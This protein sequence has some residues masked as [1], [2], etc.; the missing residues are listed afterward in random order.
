M[1]RIF[2][3]DHR[4]QPNVL[5]TSRPTLN[6]RPVRTRCLCGQKDIERPCSS[7][8]NERRGDSG[9][10]DQ[11]TAPPDG[12]IV[13]TEQN[14]KVSVCGRLRRRGA[15]LGKER[16]TRLPCRRDWALHARQT[17]MN[18][19]RPHSRRGSHFRRHP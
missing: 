15:Q 10:G 4:R 17:P 2:D 8:E 9:G 3:V 16:F 7:G 11:E 13:A 12:R 5:R 18:G 19:T 14:L 1:A 6:E